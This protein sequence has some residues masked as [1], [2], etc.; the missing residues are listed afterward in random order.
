MVTA[1]V[2]QLQASPEELALV[3]DDYHLLQ[4]QPIHDGMTFLLNHLRHSCT[5]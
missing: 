4:S 2:N 3:L 1:L 5:W